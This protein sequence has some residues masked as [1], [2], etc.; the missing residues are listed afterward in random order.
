[1][2]K[3]ELAQIIWEYAAA[4]QH[5]M[6]KEGACEKPLFCTHS[7]LEIIREALWQ[8]IKSS[9]EDASRPSWD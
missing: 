8:F 4:V 7:D 6:E 2:N 1:M 3:Y 5:N 9:G